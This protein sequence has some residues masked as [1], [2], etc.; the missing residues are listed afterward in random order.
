MKAT[1]GFLTSFIPGKKSSAPPTPTNSSAA[2][3]TSDLPSSST[4]NPFA[5]PSTASTDPP[6]TNPIEIRSTNPFASTIPSH[7]AANSTPRTQSG[8][9]SNHSSTSSPS[10][11]F[12]TPSS[13]SKS[14]SIDP[15]ARAPPQPIRS[16]DSSSCTG[17]H[18]S[19]SFSKSSKPPTGSSATP[20]SSSMRGM[21]SSASTFASS[22]LPSTPSSVSKMTSAFT[23][24]SAS[25]IMAPVKGIGAMTSA[26]GSVVGSAMAPVG[27]GLGVMTSAAGSAVSSAA[28]MLMPTDFPKLFATSRADISG[29]YNPDM[30]NNSTMDVSEEAR[31][32]LAV[33]G[34]N[35]HSVLSNPRGGNW[36]DALLDALTLPGETE[37]VLSAMLTLPSISRRDFDGYMKNFSESSA[38]YAKNHEIPVQ[39]QLASANVPTVQA[40]NEDVA[41]CFQ[42]VPSLYFKSDYEFSDPTTFDAVLGTDSIQASQEQLSG[43]LDRV[44][45]SLLRQVSSRSDRFFEASTSQGDMKKRVM[46]ACDQVRHLRTTMDRLRNSL[47]D[48]S[49]AIL[50]LHRKQKRLVELHEL[51]VQIEEMKHTESSVE[52]LVHGHDYTGAL[53]AIDMALK[54]IQQMAGIHCVR[55]LGDKLQAYRSFIGVQMATRF[56]TVVTSSEWPFEPVPPPTNPLALQSLQ[57]KQKEMTEEMKQLMDALFRLD[58]VPDVMGKYRTRMTEEIKI[59][60][61]TVVSETIASS[62]AATNSPDKGDAATALDVTSQLRALSSEEFLNCVQMI[63]EHLLMVLQRAMSVQTM[64]AEMYQIPVTVADDSNAE[65]HASGTSDG[66]WSPDNTTGAS[67]V[68]LGDASSADHLGEWQEKKKASKILQDVQDA[69]RK[70][71]EFSQRSVSNLFG[72]RKEVQANYTMPQLRSLYDATMAFVVQLEQSTG[73][74]DYTLRGALFNQLKLFLEKYHQAQ[75]TKLVSTLNHELWKNAEISAF[76]HVALVD[77]ATGKGVSLV[78]SHDQSVGAEMA[79]PLKQLTLP[80]ASFRVVWSVLFAMEIVMNYLSLAVNFPVLATDVLQRTTEILRLYNSRTTQLVLGAG[81]MQV[82]HLKSI[83]AKHLGLASQSLEVIVAFIPHI[84]FQLAALLTQRQKLLLDELDKVLQDYVEHNDKIFGKFISIVEDQIMK[85]FLEH[86][87]QDVDYDDGNLVLPSA[88]LK[89]IAQNTVKLYQVLSPVLPPLQMQAVFSRVFDMLEH[90]MP[91][92]FKAVQPKTAA[93]K[94]R[95]VADVVAFVDCFKELHGAV[96]VRG[97]QLVAHFRSSYT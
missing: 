26:A 35:L 94:Q 88:P 95:V 19:N 63:F 7:S 55:P 17:S 22:M 27:K 12:A 70:T 97:D 53:D 78:L 45:V 2:A 57:L 16:T 79:A 4:G 14:L 43:Y 60:V 74:T 49:L 23:S 52:A 65:P 8:H 46:Q 62:S 80:T 40:A 31:E 15:T 29:F 77:L 24:T 48:K 93:G 71:C 73:K 21:M 3:H 68:G 91:A 9:T 75:A 47:A 92:C 51:M 50:Q 54:T 10:N 85:K 81:A 37:A 86:I 5:V 90:K 56:T 41:L 89:G 33:S 61:K 25:V 11:P 84:K 42:A 36:G 76:R 96:D 6:V 18:S 72:V 66:E 13:S 83:S 30:D 58:L 34:H 64:L 32:F 87:D 38:V 59:V 39:E 20:T 67:A 1:T 28:D 44:E 69:I 82:A